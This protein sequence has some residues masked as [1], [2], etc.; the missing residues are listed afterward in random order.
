[1][2]WDYHILRGEGNIEGVSYVGNGFRVMVSNVLTLDGLGP[3]VVQVPSE[4][5]GKASTS[6]ELA[7]SNQSW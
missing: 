5:R 1:M 2:R 4:C 7:L 3:T 6:R